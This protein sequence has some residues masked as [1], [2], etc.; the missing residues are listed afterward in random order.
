MAS[1]PDLARPRE[2]PELL[3][4]SSLR[5]C[6]REATD[7]CLDGLLDRNVSRINYEML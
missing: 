1:V 3:K 4:R 7:Y 6:H 2:P 5:R